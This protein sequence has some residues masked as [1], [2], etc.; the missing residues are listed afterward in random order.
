MAQTIRIGLVGAG[1]IATWHAD[2]IRSLPGLELTAVCDVSPAAAEALASAYGLP[3]FSS[4]DEMAASGLCDAAHVLT[5]PHLHHDLAIECLRA[6][7]HVFVEKPFAVTAREAGEMVAV[8]ELAGKQVGAGHNFLGV[9]SYARLKRMADEGQLGRISHAEI[10]WAFPLG[11]LRAGP[12]GLWMLREPQNLLLELG[13]HLFA[14]A[15][16]LFGS[17]EISHL[18]LAHPIALPGSGGTRHQSWRIL[19]RAGQVEI[20]VNVATVETF[21]DRSITLRGSTGLARLDY[22]AD[23]L[24][25]MRENA[26][27]I[28]VNP[29][30]KQLALAAQNLRDGAVNAARQLASLNR[31]SPYG[32]SFQNAISGFYD[33]IRSSRPD[34]RFSGETAVRVIE[35][36]E[37]VNSRL[38]RPDP[39]PRKPRRTPQPTAL[40]IGGTGFIGQHLVRGLVAAGRDVRVLSRGAHGPFA[41]IA[42]QVEMKSASLKDEASLAQTMEGIEVVFNLARSLDK[43]WEAA[44]ENDVGVSDGIARAAL[45]AGVKRLVYTGTIAS[46]DMSDPLVTITEQTGFAA[47]MSDRNLYA[48]SKAECERRLMEMYSSEGLPITVARPGIVLGEYGPLQHWGIGRWHGAGAVR[49]WGSGRNILPFVLIEDVVDGLI[50]MGEDPAAEG[51]SFNLVGEPM[52]SARDYFDA[53][54]DAFGARI[55]VRPGSMLAFWLGD[56]VKYALK[57]H[58]LRKRGVIRPSLRDWKSR[59]HLSRFDNGLPKRL[60]GWQP[61]A[62]RSAFYRRAVK[63]VNL[64]GF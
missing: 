5:Q 45:K 35:A 16:D 63:E 31:K 49:V 21:D 1:Y 37:A 55:L 26:S 7:L 44:L 61:E 19:A 57:S 32:L 22:A 41:D 20:T 51:E 50:R 2:A 47:D 62:D 42:G 18:E 38:P 59:G 17:P 23:T 8:A 33:G 24:L 27:D 54:H 12:F 64:F 58:V 39:K 11:P 4:I 9:P 14:F 30:R 60:L 10:T 6:G 52:W 3:A 29:A 43:S 56:F 40:V 13:P 48:R 34:P 15:E 46:Y 25:V 53:I 36:I 28:I